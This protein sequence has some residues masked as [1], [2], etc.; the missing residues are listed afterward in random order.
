MTDDATNI[1]EHRYFTHKELPGENF[2][3]PA[4]A[5][6]AYIIVKAEQAMEYVKR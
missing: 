4:N 1:D 3:T 2:D 5:E 6:L